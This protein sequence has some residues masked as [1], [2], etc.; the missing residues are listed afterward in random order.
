MVCLAVIGGL[1]FTALSLWSRRKAANV[2]QG[3]SEEL[4]D[5]LRTG[6]REG[7]AS[8]LLADLG[9]VEARERRSE[10][11]IQSELEALG[12]KA[13][14]ALIHA[15]QDDAPRVRRISASVLGSLETARAVGPLL[16]V[17]GGDDDIY[18]RVAVAGALGRI[19]GPGT[20]PG[21]RT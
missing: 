4:I 19:G 2:P 6:D 17:L 11:E 13:V 5:E 21:T 14:P 1:L 3:P 15:L 12:A 10:W 16:E 20:V 18:V 8:E 9:V 7:L